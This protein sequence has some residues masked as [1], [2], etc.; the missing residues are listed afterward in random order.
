MKIGDFITLRNL[1]IIAYQDVERNLP[2]PNGQF[3]AM[4]NPDSIQESY[5]AHFRKKQAINSSGREAV[6]LFNPPEELE[7]TLLLHGSAPGLPFGQG[8]NMPVNIR[9]KV[10]QFKKVAYHMNGELHEPNFLRLKWGATFDFPCRLLS[11]TVKYTNFSSAGRPTQAEIEARFIHDE[12]RSDRKTR[13][14][15]SS[16][17]LTHKRM[18]KA[19]DTLPFLCKQIYGDAA[20][21][22]MVARHNELDDFRNLATGTEL[23]FPPLDVNEPT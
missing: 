7:V 11:F 14:N 5:A 18:V 4:F 21:Y 9:E 19:G 10:N 12:A 13:E 8:H 6:Y 16:P 17:D 3:E 22:L 2:I 23:H 1:H 20:Y 15:K